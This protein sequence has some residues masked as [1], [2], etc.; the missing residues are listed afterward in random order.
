MIR[1]SILR[2]VLEMVLHLL[3]IADLFIY[4]I[5]ML[6]LFF[7]WLEISKEITKKKDPPHKEG[8]PQEQDYANTILFL[9]YFL[10]SSWLR[11]M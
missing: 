4:F 7:Y 9:R 11:R 5:N 8:D 10:N 3:S 2:M 1:A 6:Y